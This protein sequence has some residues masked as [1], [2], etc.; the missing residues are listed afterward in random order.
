M[1]ASHSLHL[2]YTAAH[3][4]QSFPLSLSRSKHF[5]PGQSEYPL[6]NLILLCTLLAQHLSN[7]LEQWAPWCRVPFLYWS[8]FLV[9]FMAV[10]FSLVECHWSNAKKQNGSELRRALRWSSLQIQSSYLFLLSLFFHFIYRQKMWKPTCSAFIFYSCLETAV[11][12]MLCEVTFPI[13]LSFFCFPQLLS[14][15]YV[16]H[17]GNSITFFLTACYSSCKPKLWRGTLQPPSFSLLQRCHGPRSPLQAAGAAAQ[18]TELKRVWDQGRT[19]PSTPTCQL[20]TAGWDEQAL[21]IQ[22]ML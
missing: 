14:Q 7:S 15:R 22:K 8:V 3:V 13:F 4:P 18:G 19:G 9:C 1:I 17:S 21:Y 11:I 12:V 10:A 2:S 6:E 16:I 5:H 20:G